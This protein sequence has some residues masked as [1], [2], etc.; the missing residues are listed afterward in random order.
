[1]NSIKAFE[2]L[3]GHISGGCTL[4]GKLSCN[5]CLSGEIS[6]PTNYPPYSGDY[7]V[8]PN[9]FSAQV[10]PTANK[11]LMQDVVV[12][13]IPYYETSNVQQGITVYIAEEV[14]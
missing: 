3:S 10:L 4:S 7:E 8:V 5:G 1:M 12:Q 6:L 13:K 2:S 14:I 9:A 11:S